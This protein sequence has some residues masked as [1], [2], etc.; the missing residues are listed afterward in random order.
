MN[1]IKDAVLSVCAAM[2]FSG[3]MLLLAPSGGE[4]TLRFVMSLVVI[5]VLLSTVSCSENVEI[6]KIGKSEFEYTEEL[7][8]SAAYSSVEAFLNDNNLK[9]SSLSVFTDKTDNGSIFISK[10][11]VTTSEPDADVAG[12]LKLEFPTAEVVAEHG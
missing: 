10:I 9:F 8:S 7:A 4:K 3:I 1:G 2:V 6:P 12:F 5:C 11:C